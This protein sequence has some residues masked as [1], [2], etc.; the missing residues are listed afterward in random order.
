MVKGDSRSRDLVPPN[1]GWGL[2]E[3]EFQ[4][5]QDSMTSPGT[6]GMFGIFPKLPAPGWH[7][8]SNS[9]TQPSPFSPTPVG[10]CGSCCSLSDTELPQQGI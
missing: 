5:L 1:D 7:T 2:C 9:A 3:A 6:R 10:S 4:T 8:Q